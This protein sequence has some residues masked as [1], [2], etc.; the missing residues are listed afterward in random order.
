MEVEVVEGSSGI[1]RRKMF[2]SSSSEAQVAGLAAAQILLITSCME[3]CTASGCYLH[4][5]EEEEEN[6]PKIQML[7]SFTHHLT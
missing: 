1:E 4:M 3:S 7:H 5:E 2:S 6:R